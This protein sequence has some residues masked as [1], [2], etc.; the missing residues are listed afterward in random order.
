MPALP[1]ASRYPVIMNDRFLQ[2]RPDELMKRPIIACSKGTTVVVIC[3]A[4]GETVRAGK[5]YCKFKYVL[6][7][8]VMSPVSLPLF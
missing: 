4:W 6:E 8:H 5:L 1:E 3:R 2:Y 7:S